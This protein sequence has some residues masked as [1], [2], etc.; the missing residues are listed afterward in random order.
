MRYEYTTINCPYDELIQVLDE[1]G[2]AGWRVV[3]VLGFGNL[4]GD[5]DVVLE[6]MLG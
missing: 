1:W 6:R 3:Q 5:V 4:G 2:H